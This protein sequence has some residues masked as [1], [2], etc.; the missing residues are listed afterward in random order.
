ML[1]RVQQAMTNQGKQPMTTLMDVPQ[2]QLNQGI[3][4]TDINWFQEHV[5]RRQQ[6]PDEHEGGS[7]DEDEQPRRA[8]NRTRHVQ[9]IQEESKND[10]DDDED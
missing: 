8:R 2:R 9:Q 7:D 3:S 4:N 10:S 5:G 1:E 6:R